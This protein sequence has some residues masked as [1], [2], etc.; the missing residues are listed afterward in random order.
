MTKEDVKRYISYEAPGL[1]VVDNEV[2]EVVCNNDGCDGRVEVDPATLVPEDPDAV[3][4]EA[5][6]P[7][8]MNRYQV[9]IYCSSE[10]RSETYGGNVSD[11]EAEEALEEVDL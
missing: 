9:E 2:S 8:T 7:E 1:G 4:V 10:C 5:R 11:K 3:D 6:D